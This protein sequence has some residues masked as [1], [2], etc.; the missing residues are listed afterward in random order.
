MS[1][2]DDWSPARIVDPHAPEPVVL[3]EMAD[4]RRTWRQ[5]RRQRMGRKVWPAFV[6]LLVLVIAGSAVLLGVLL[7][8]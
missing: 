7:E 2:V 3:G 5:Q 1:P 6:V 4:V 8:F